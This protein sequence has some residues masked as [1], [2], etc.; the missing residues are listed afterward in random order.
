MNIGKRKLGAVIQ[1]TQR[2]IEISMVT[3][4][5][6]HRADLQTTVEFVELK[7]HAPKS[8][9]SVQRMLMG[10]HPKEMM[11]KPLEVPEGP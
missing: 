7:H 8:I 1:S 2:R 3:S 4:Q 10:E 6:V 5:N 11:L 9:K